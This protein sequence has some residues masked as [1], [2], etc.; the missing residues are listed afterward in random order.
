MTFGEKL[1]TLRKQRGLSQDALAEKMNT[2]RQAISKWENDQGF[3]ETE[4]LLLLS[5]VLNVSIDYLLKSNEKEKNMNPDGFYV[6]KEMADGF[7]YNERKS[8][9]FVACGIFSLILIYIPF[10]IFK[11]DK[12][13]L[14]LNVMILGVIGI[15]FILAALLFDDKKYKVIK[16]K[17][18]LFDN[19]V[20]NE[21]KKKYNS[22]KRKYYIL[23][24]LGVSFIVLGALPILLD[25][26]V[27]NNTNIFSDSY[28]GFIFFID[29]GFFIFIRAASLIEAYEI[30]V[31]NQDY[32]NKLTNRVIKRFKSLINKI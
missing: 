12:T 1:R 29:V 8:S 32:T 26:K 9:N 19:V 25:V 24:M 2:T 30:L 20:L 27:F 22:I 17:P 28:L 16:E 6:S 18:L 7:L 14:L 11:Y 31:N 5:N 10:I 23:A 21:L 3:P 13:V 15:S 4:K